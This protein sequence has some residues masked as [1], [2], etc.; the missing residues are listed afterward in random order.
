MKT[1]AIISQKGGCGKST[2]AIHLAVC[3]VK[4]GLTVA[5]FDID[6]KQESS[7]EWFLTRGK[8][9]ELIVLQALA[10]QLPELLKQGKNGGID[11]CIIDTAPHTDEPMT[12]AAAVADFVLVPTK[13]YTLEL[14]A[15]PKTLEALR[16]VKTPH[17]I[18]INEAPLGHQAD[19]ARAVLEEQGYPV[20]NTVIGDRVAFKH[21]IADGL[22]VHEY[23]PEGKAVEELTELF[24]EI[25]QEM[26][27]YGNTA[28]HKTIDRRKR[29]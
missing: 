5:L 4:D 8:S 14:R 11:L 27:F 15:I 23:E 3:A 1:L 19:R 18:V 29:A 7:Y 10:N 17:S 9:N 2:L 16:L 25:K 6:H 22:A 12:A 13:P 24:E 20:L 26:R 21:A 28:N